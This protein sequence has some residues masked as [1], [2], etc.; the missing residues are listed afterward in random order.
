MFRQQAEETAGHRAP[1]HGVDQ[2]AAI[3]NRHP[4]GIQGVHARGIPH[5]GLAH[6]PVAHESRPR[7]EGRQVREE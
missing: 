2:L 3:E 7:R 5:G 6:L 4:D 1:R